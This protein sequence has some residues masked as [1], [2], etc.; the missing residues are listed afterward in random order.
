MDKSGQDIGKALKELD[1]QGVTVDKKDLVNAL[2]SKISKLRGK[3]SQKDLIKGLE[4]HIE[5][6]KEISIFYREDLFLK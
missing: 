6:L 5:D 3:E 1:E 2:Q 4:G